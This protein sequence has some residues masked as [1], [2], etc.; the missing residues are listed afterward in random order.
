[1]LFLSQTVIN[2]KLR[3]VKHCIN[4]SESFIPWEKEI[5]IIILFYLALTLFYFFKKKHTHLRITFS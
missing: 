2:N 3:K 1:M 5:M 4:T